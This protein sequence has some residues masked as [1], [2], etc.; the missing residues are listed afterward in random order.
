[1]DRE[2]FG[3][4]TIVVHFKREL[5]SHEERKACKHKYMY[6]VLAHAEHTETGERFVVYRA[7]DDGKEWARPEEEF[8]SKV[9]KDKY[10]DVKQEYRL[11]PIWEW[12]E[13]A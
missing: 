13:L 7:L 1:M 9:D 2:R 12:Q 5:M 3:L 4:G 6:T 10:P 8:Y 11:I